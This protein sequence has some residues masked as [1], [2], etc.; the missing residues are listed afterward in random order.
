[1]RSPS[2]GEL[3]ALW[4]LAMAI[5]AAVVVLAMTGP[6]EANSIHNMVI[7]GLLPNLAIVFGAIRN[8]GQKEV[9]NKMAEQLGAS[10]PIS[11]D[12]QVPPLDLTGAELD[13]RAG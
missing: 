8:I 5:I 3:L 11:N 9:M 12:N 2:S 6:A 4:S 13:R 10:R 1:M 7:T